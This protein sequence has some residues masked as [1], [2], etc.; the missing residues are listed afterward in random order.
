M[1]KGGEYMITKQKVF[2]FFAAMV[3]VL[4][5]VVA[6]VPAYAATT[7]PVHQN[8]FQGLVQ[9]IAQKFGLDKGE[10]QSAV[11]DF[12]TQHKEQVQSQLQTRENTHLDTLVSQGK[13]TASQ[14]Q[15]ILDEQ[16]KLRSEYDPSTFKNLTPDQRKQKFQQEQA[17]IQAWSKST[18]I[19][20]KY[21]RPGFM[22]FGRM[23]MFNRWDKNTNPSVTPSPSI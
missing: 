3:L 10:V 13:I 17:E 16:A 9:F 22:G 6:A 11:D 21:L 2:S 8:F 23:R 14:K 19:D 1:V 12:R 7:T 5:P 4:T 15:Q 20:A 18:G